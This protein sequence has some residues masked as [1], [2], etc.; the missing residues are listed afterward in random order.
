MLLIVI[1]LRVARNYSF[2]GYFKR[3][4]I[5]P[6]YD[7]DNGFVG[8]LRLANQSEKAARHEQPNWLRVN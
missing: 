3:L 7:P 8:T 4:T 5:S 2:I 1:H 6:Q